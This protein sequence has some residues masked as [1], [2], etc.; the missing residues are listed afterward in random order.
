MAHRL[1]VLNAISIRQFFGPRKVL[2]FDIVNIDIGSI[3]DEMNSSILL[4]GSRQRDPD[5]F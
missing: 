1:E 3:K 2:V 4:F 5:G